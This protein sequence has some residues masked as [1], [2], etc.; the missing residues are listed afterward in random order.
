MNMPAKIQTVL[1]DQLGA[2][3]VE[4]EDESHRHAGHRGNN[5]GGHYNVVVVSPEFSGKTL[6]ERHRM[7]HDALADEMKVAIHALSL[8]TYTPEQWQA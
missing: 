2:L 6:M 4:V 3:V 1:R 5:G 8:K 7:V